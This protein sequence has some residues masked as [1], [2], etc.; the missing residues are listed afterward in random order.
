MVPFPFQLTP[1]FDSPVNNPIEP[2]HLDIDENLE[3]DP[4]DIILNDLLRL[5]IAE[6]PNR[7]VK[8]SQA[9]SIHSGLV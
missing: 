5:A 6:L 8:R 7:F 1:T 4:L 3:I 9:R 2:L